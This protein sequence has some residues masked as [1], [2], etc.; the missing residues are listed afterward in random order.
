MHKKGRWTKKEEAYLKENYLNMTD[1]EIAAVLGRDKANIRHKRFREGWTK[2]ERGNL[3][4]EQ[5]TD[6]LKS[7]G[8]L[9]TMKTAAQVLGKTERQVRYKLNVLGIT[10]P[11]VDIKKFDME[12]FNINVVGPEEKV[13]ALYHNDTY[14]TDGTLEYLSEWTGNKASYLRWLAQPSNVDRSSVKVM[15]IG[16]AKEFK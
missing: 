8:S 13:Y 16:L 10:P 15:Y 4:S 2:E 9:L 6:Y 7:V 14:V 5:E 11:A 3:W 1:K 12:P